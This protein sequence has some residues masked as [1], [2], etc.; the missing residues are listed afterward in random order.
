MKIKKIISIILTVALCLTAV[1]IKADAKEETVKEFTEIWT[2]EDLY[3]INNN[4][5]GNYRL[6]NDID[7]SAQTA[8]GGSW[9]TGHAADGDEY[10]KALTPTQMSIKNMYTGFD[11]EN[12]WEIDPNS[13]YK[14]PQLKGNRQQRVEGISI[15]TLPVKLSYA[16][17]EDIDT[18]G[19]TVKITYE[20]G[21]ETIVLLTKDMI[22]GYDMTA[23]GEQN[24][25]VSYGGKSVQFP[26]EVG[27]IDV[28]SVVISGNSEMQKGTSSKLSAS[29]VPQN[30]TDNSI[31]W[32]SSDESKATVDADGNVTAL[33][34]GEVTITAAA[35]NGV[36]A[37]YKIN[38]TA[39]CVLL[40]LDESS[41]TLYKGD[42]KEIGT[43]LSPIDTTDK[44][45]W[46][47][48]NSNIASVD[49]Y[50]VITAV[51]PGETTIKAK[52]GNAKASC[53]VIVKQNLSSFYIVGV[54]DKAYTG[55]SVEQNIKVTDGNV[56][57]NEDEDYIVSYSDNVNVG[58]AE[59]TIFGI[60][61]YEG[62][63]KKAFKII[64]NKNDNY[65]TDDSANDNANNNK[66]DNINNNKSDN[67]NNKGTDKKITVGK[68]TIKKIRNVKGRKIEIQYN[69]IN[70][71]DGYQI[72]YSLKS[73]M[74]GSS[75]TKTTTK[76]KY[77]LTSLKKKKKYYIQVRAFGYDS[78]DKKV[79]GK[80]SAKKSV[81]INK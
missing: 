49:N 24:V 21:Y 15:E 38:I 22:S 78:S 8:K 1:P 47:S 77:T 75:K 16:Q 25:T 67:T 37:D 43:K 51:S 58:T 79:Y 60:G 40:I 36:S 61:Y 27:R 44:V 45:T 18:D 13:S 81:K 14:Y 7:I 5:K 70:K 23:V 63:L 29:V 80:W 32:S 59:M 46:N 62:S 69:K 68:V 35:S 10:A 17:G 3:G 65:V 54:E 6:M 74:M 30:A 4:P 2:I 31:K 48:S 34:T 64:S 11:F 72:R 19:G 9:D 41:V 20:G 50:G 39:S 66:N 42:T 57:L 33:A 56:T 71:A 28:T 26:I 53:Q 12:T 55:D 52:A 73:N 76:T